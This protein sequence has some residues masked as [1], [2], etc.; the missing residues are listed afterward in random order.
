MTLRIYRARTISDAIAEVKRDLGRDAVILHTR[1]L[2]VGGWLG[3]G[4]RRVVEVTASDGV[5]VPSRLAGGRSCEPP[6]PGTSESAAV[7]PPPRFSPSALHAPSE[8][9]GSS[10]AAALA[11]ELHAIKR[12]VGQVLRRGV[13]TRGA[14]SE[15]RDVG[16]GSG[17]P[18]AVGHVPHALFEVYVQLIEREVAAEIAE[19]IIG[20]VR[21]EL[22]PADLGNSTRVREAVVRRLAALIPCDEQAGT[23]SPSPDERPLVVAVVGPTGVGKTTTVAKLAAACKLRQNRRVGLITTDTYRIAAVDQLRTYAEIIG[24]PLRVVLS[25]GEMPAAL[26]ALSDCDVVLMDTAG[27]SPR[28]A[29]RL[30]DLRRFVQAARPHQTHLVLSSTASEPALLEAARRFACVAPNRVIFTKLDEAVSFG[31]LVGVARQVALKLS[32]ITTGQEVPDHIEVGRPE[33]VARL[34]LEGSLSR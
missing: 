13:S 12:L 10:L 4:G 32:F 21:D 11:S 19:E 2:R 17:L 7:V 6:P 22:S 24:L 23:L 26:A 16:A 31:V 18:P 3:I 5:S 30:E 14:V 25:P 20:Q 9:T 27:R 1:H 33:R 29:D 28:D 15:P 8:G 34:V